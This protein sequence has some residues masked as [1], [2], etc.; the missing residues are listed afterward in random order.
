MHPIL[1]EFAGVRVYAYGVFVA[2][3]GIICARF[4]HQRRAAMGLRND[5][6][7]WL[8]INAL[9]IGG[10]IGGRLLFLFEYTRPF[11]A[12][13]W[14]ALI[15]LSRGFS[16]MGGFLGVASALWWFTRRTKTSLLLVDHVAVVAPLWHAVGRVGCFFAGCCFGR[17]T[18]R[19]WGVTFR[20]PRST[21]DQ[22]LLGRPLHPTQLYEAL[23]DLLIAALLY[24]VVMPAVVDGRQPRGTV[25]AAYW[26]SYG[27]LR[28]VTEYFRGDIVALG[29]G[30]TAAQ[31]FSLAF[32]AAGAAFYWR[33]RCSRS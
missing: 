2:V 5:E 31:G 4:W 19:F 11:S 29:L 3:G 26:A 13:F 20:D 23:G 15:S 32:I 21:V 22:V 12:E 1:I 28:F 18:D 16:V 9:V 33:L 10:F 25:T 6:E 27:L 30:L 8:L 17:P 24:R 7:F 14:R